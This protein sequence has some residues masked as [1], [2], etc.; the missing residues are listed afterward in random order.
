MITIS[1]FAFVHW[2]DGLVFL[3]PIF[4]IVYSS[5]QIVKYIRNGYKME[6]K[7]KFINNFI[8]VLL[9]I[10]TSFVAAISEDMTGH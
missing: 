1:M 4:L 6:N 2:Y 5:W 7:W 8:V 9:I 3:V 10:S